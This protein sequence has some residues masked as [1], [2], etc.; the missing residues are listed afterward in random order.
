MEHSGIQPYPFLTGQKSLHPSAPLE[1]HMMKARWPL[2][3]LVTYWEWRSLPLAHRAQH[4]YL[5]TDSLWYFWVR[6][7]C[8]VL[9]SFCWREDWRILIPFPPILPLLLFFSFVFFWFKKTLMHCSEKLSLLSHEEARPQRL[10]LSLYLYI[11][12]TKPRRWLFYKYLT[13]PRLRSQKLLVHQN[14]TSSLN[15]NFHP[16]FG[17][18]RIHT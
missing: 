3:V 12:G 11:C 6:L 5:L 15:A 13:K 9:N 16:S 14:C 4:W 8:L 18:D 10:R 7:P 17:D 1:H 2:L